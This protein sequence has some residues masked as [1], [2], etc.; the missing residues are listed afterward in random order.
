MFLQGSLVA[1]VTPFLPTSELD[2]EGFLRLLDFHLAQGTDGIVVAGTTGESPTLTEREWE[3]LIVLARERIG[4]RLPLVVGSGTNDTRRSVARTRRAAELGAD[5]C[6]VVTPYY[7]RPT[8]EGLYA[9]FS[10]IARETDVP[11]VLYNVPSRTACD[12]LPTTVARLA[13][14]EPRIVGLKEATAGTERLAS[15]HKAV[16]RNDFLFLS[17]DDPTALAFL[18]AGGHGIVSV[19]ANVAPRELHELCRH[20]RMGE[21]ARAHEI[22]RRLAELNRLLFVEPNPIPVKWALHELG[23]I[24]PT[25]RLPL[26]PLSVSHRSAL[27]DALRRAD[28]LPLASVV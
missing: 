8:Q 15:L 10:T 9:H 25:L 4:G 16:T 6:L 18:L 1:I 14:D 23:W 11:L 22:E 2:E 19:T 17:G 13:A 12:L 28:L 7:N 21:I 5:A 24:S 3:R 26:T 27:R 20:A